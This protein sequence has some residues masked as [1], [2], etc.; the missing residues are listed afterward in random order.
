MKKILYIVIAFFL[1]GLY[2]S[3]N[4]FLEE[5]Q[6]SSKDIESAFQSKDD[7]F[8]AVNMLYRNGVSN[9]FN[10]GSAYIAPYLF[11]GGY[12]TGLFDNQYAGQH[13]FNSNIYS[14]TID[15][16]VNDGELVNLWRQAYQE[17]TRFANFALVG[18]PICP[19]LS[20]TERA[21][22]M[23][24]A[25][26][27]RALNY[28][29]LVKNFGEVPIVDK[30]MVSL[31]D[32][33]Y[34]R[35]SS[36][37]AVYEFILADLNSAL[38]DGGLPDKSM[39]DNALRVT[40]GS[41]LA[42]LADVNLNMAGYPLNDVSKYAEAAQ[43]AKM[44][45][46]NSAYALIQ[47]TDKGTKSVYNILRTSDAEKE[48][49]YQMEF[50]GSITQGGWYPTYAFPMGWVANNPG[51]IKY[52]I[53]CST[54][55]P[56]AGLLKIYD[57]ND[58]L[59]IQEGQYFHTSYKGIAL[60]DKGSRYPH[61]FVEEEALEST[62]LS[63]KDR[64]MYRTAEMYLTFAEADVMSK[65]T[66]GDDAID[67][68]ATIQARASLNKTKD[69]IK[70]TLATLSKDEFVQEVWRERIRELMF[71]CKIWNDVTRTRMYPDI[72]TPNISFIPVIGAKT[73]YSATFQEKDLLY[74]YPN[75]EIQ[76]NPNLMQEPIN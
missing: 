55:N 74:P 16:S 12:R 75:S 17:I 20:D 46:D 9:Y 56:N 44:I 57:A 47:S 38:T 7:G 43:Y 67:A 13:L 54:Y 68:L 50:E 18:I 24:E 60:D 29:Y 28:F 15:S 73:P 33:I 48:Y 65:G 8:A 30:P 36:V 4:D 71:E 34:P 31:N 52:S 27:F 32:D 41:V 69:Q 39:P 3:C 53:T 58:D 37:K 21:Q 6:Q 66:V 62:A 5:K 64:V 22:L 19:G 26:F 49:L 70:A 1:I 76:R 35:R 61:F 11:Y 14:M 10:A 59:R 25:K 23:A 42:L 2:S 40:K 72:S 45:K 63:S 51:V